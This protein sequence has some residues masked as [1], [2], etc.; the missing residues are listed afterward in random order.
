MARGRSL[1]PWFALTVVVYLGWAVAGAAQPS[2]VP[3]P[4]RDF[5]SGLQRVHPDESVEYTLQQRFSLNEALAAV[6]HVRGALT[7]FEQLTYM[8]RGKLPAP[9]IA[10]IGYTEPEMQTIG[11]RNLPG[12]LEG[13]LRLQEWTIAKLWY[14]LAVER[15]RTEALS[16]QEVATAKRTFEAA[17][18]SFRQFWNTFGVAD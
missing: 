10:Q 18:A 8:T 5:P 17:D 9:V 7:S 14:D 16:D 1:F 12:T 11:F 2:D 13:A 3:S 6:G 15:R 4:P